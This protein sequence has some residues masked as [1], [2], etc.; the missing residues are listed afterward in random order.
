MKS[1]FRKRR[2]A[3]QQKTT[4]IAKPRIQSR[5]SRSPTPGT[6]RVAYARHAYVPESAKD[7]HGRGNQE[8]CCHDYASRVLHLRID[9]GRCCSVMSSPNYLITL[10]LFTLSR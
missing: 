1:V 2:P 3:F 8:G 4:E 10:T 9:L 5:Q 6:A 7:I